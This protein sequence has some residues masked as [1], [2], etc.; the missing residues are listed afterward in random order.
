MAKKH[1]RL[2]S[3][4]SEVCAFWAP[5]AA[6]VVRTGTVTVDE[7]RITFTTA[8]EYTRQ[9]SAKQLFSAL[10]SFNGGPVERLPVLHGFTE[11]GLCTLCQLTEVD[12][13][14]LADYSSSQS[15]M[16]SAYR[17][18]VCITGIHLGGISEKS[19]TSA[20]YTLTGLGDWLP[21]ARTE[22]WEDDYVVQRVPIE[23]KE[24]VAFAL[25]ENR[26]HVSLKV[27]SEL[28]NSEIDGARVHR[29]IPYVEI[30]SS[31]PESLSWYL[32]IGNRLENLFSLLTGT[33]L[34]LETMFVYRGEE[35]GHVIAKRNTHVEPFARFDCVRCTPS[36]LANAI[37]IWLCESQEFRSIENLALGVLR[38]GKLFTETEF[39]S[40]AQAL[41]GFHRV[42]TPKAVLNKAVIRKV[43]KKFAVL[44][45]EENVD[46]TLA[47]K[48]CIS[49]SHANDPSF[50]SRLFGLCALISSSLLHK[51]AIALEKF[52]AD[53]VVTRNFYTHAGS[54]GVARRERTPI[55]GP[56]CSF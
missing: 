6:D 34:A 49:M 48:L 38:R 23:A 1:I 27:F 50:S 21:E 9:V 2:D 25:R 13:P 5:E 7:S 42:T 31:T 52:V 11:S 53:V 44:L 36:Q 41:E 37:A 24:I 16:A 10:R 35:S 45:K 51:M 54:R 14:G 40:L 55:S 15:I 29:S 19:V 12:Q 28:T 3:Q 26:V 8:P 43:R 22:S 17:A 46:A 47:E 56:S 39:L 20:R 30:E 4:F 33:S 18:T 32:D